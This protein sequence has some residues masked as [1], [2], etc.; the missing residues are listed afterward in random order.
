[1]VD[2]EDQLTAGED[3]LEQ[4]DGTVVVAHRSEGPGVV[5]PR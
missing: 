1:M 2:A 3:R 4:S 5:A